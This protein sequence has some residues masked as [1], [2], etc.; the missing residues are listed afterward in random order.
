MDSQQAIQ[1]LFIFD[2]WCTRE[3]TDFIK[4]SG[5]FRER[6][7]CTALLSH[8]INS[9]RI[10]FDRVL[11]MD[12]ADVN[13]WDEID[14][15]EMKQHAQE[16]NQLWIDLIGD[17]EMDIDTRIVYQ[18]FAGVNY[19]NTFTEICNHL[20]LH[21][22]HHRAQISLLLSRSEIT[23]PSIDYIHYLRQKT[24]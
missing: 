3:L 9:Q 1:R 21:G 14:I 8:I 20:I 22:Q 18:N 15:D 19:M 4:V 6:K 16:A 11:S 13:L 24:Q 23:P 17:H 5:E 10:W 7:L 12:I 2:L